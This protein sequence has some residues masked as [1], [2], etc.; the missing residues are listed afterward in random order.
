MDLKLQDKG[1]AEETWSSKLDAADVLKTVEE[2]GLKWD[3]RCI[4]VIEQTPPGA[5]IDFKISFRDPDP[6]WTS[7]GGRIVKIG[8]AAHAFI[9]NSTQGATQAME[10]GQSLAACLKLATKNNIPMATRVHTKL[11][12]VLPIQNAFHLLSRLITVLKLRAHFMC[13]EE[14]FQESRQMGHQRL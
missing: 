13:T 11:R 6:H 12:C 9:P 8:D 5:I 10:D 2:S 1:A 3:K 4:S 7:N 14:W